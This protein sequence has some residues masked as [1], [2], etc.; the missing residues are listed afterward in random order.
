VV[1]ASLK[2]WDGT[3]ILGVFETEPIAVRSC[4][5]AGID[6]ECEDF[7]LDFIEMNKVSK[8]Q[9]ILVDHSTYGK[10]FRRIHVYEPNPIENIA[11]E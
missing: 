10:G 7:N 8:C 1:V 6:T 5:E 9:T 4:K 2:S 11:G 3:R